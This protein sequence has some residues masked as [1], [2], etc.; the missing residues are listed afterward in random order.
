VRELLRNPYF[1]V[2]VDDDRRC[3]RRARTELGFRSIPEAEATYAGV[4]QAVESV[5]RAHHVL[6]ADMRLAPPRN[7]PAF[8]ELV[9]RYYP[10]LY[11]GFR[12][13]AALVKTQA[14][15]L[16]LTRLNEG[17]NLGVRT[18]VDEGDAL[19]YLEGEPRPS[20][21]RGFY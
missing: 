9:M 15:R 11:G 16:Q 8:E 7:D 21:R 3:L 17:T 14:G 5:Q 4:L 20:S 10:R 6:L 1:I 13:A 12:R 2:T 18:F 19:A